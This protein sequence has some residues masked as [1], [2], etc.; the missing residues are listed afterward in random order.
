MT[1]GG[2]PGG[3][4]INSGGAV[5]GPA[6]LCWAFRLAWEEA[7]LRRT[8][9]AM[10]APIRPRVTR[11]QAIPMGGLCCASSAFPTTSR[12]ASADNWPLSV[13]RASNKPNPTPGGVAPLNEKL[14]AATYVHNTIDL[15]DGTLLQTFW[16]D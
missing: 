1:C 3:D 7:A 10:V 11:W 9:A 15:F 2:N 12:E 6:A 16:F 8:M 13:F 5:R 4:R 14:H